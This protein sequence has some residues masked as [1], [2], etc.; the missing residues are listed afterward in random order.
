MKKKKPGPSLPKL[1]TAFK[2]SSPVC[3]VQPLSSCRRGKL[4]FFV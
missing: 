2:R 1:L 3:V 4:T